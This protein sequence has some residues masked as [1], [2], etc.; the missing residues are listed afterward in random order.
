[1]NTPPQRL[2]REAI[3]QFKAIYLEE[4]GEILSDDEAQQMGYEVL[5]LFWILLRSSS[6]EADIAGPR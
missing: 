4:F 2:S 1:V 5:H 3:D 6:D